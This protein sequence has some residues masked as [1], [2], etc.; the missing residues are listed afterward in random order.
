MKNTTLIIILLLSS[1]INTFAQLQYNDNL[2][3]LDDERVNPEFVQVVKEFIDSAKKSGFK[4]VIKEAYRSFERAKELNQINSKKNIAAA[5][6]SV[7]SF[8]LAIDIWLANDKNEAFSFNATNYK[9]NKENRFSYSKWMKFI[10][11]GQS[12]RLVN[13]Y[14]HNDTDHWELHP[15][16]DKNDWVSA[17]KVILPIYNRYSNLSE[18]ER[19]KIIWKDAGL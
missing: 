6:V 9:K 15:N 5:S 17:R 18:I 10:K 11:I 1:T 8:G 16:W 14:M 13:A 2:Q 12:F 4:P 3:L 7:H 19:L